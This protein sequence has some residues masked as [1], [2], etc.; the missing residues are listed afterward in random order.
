MIR[1]VPR[2]HST[3]ADAYL[4]PET[5]RYLATFSKG[6]KGQLAEDDGCQVSFMQSDGALV[7]IKNFS[8]L[9]AILCMSSSCAMANVEC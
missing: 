3:S 9:R 8:G 5:N 2:A 6:F 7:D 4:T 1:I